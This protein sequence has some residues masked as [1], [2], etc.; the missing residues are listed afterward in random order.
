[1]KRENVFALG[2]SR[3]ETA[4]P[5]WIGF[6]Y[7]FQEAAMEEARLSFLHP[8]ENAT[9]EQYK[10]PL[11]KTAYLLGRYAAKEVL[12]PCL[13]GAAR[14]SIEIAIGVFNQP[15]VKYEARGVPELS[16]A[17]SHGAAVAVACQAGHPL[18][19]DLEYLDFDKAP[20]LEP[21]FT[22]AEMSRLHGLPEGAG[23][24][25]FML[26]SAKEAL[27]KILRAGLTVPFPLLEAESFSASQGSLT[28]PSFRNFPQYRGQAWITGPYALALALPRKT[29]MTFAPGEEIRQG[30]SSA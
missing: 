4:I 28:I 26:W 10:F 3:G 7:P 29:A 27:S 5:G 6:G 11:R 17:H 15:V 22:E 20:I 19:V 9:F 30:L 25:G 21:Y 12:S 1:M 16:L 18:G 14:A 23:A 2:L 13:G 24:V 8:A